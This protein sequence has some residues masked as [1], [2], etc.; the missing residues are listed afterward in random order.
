MMTR[1]LLARVCAPAG[2]GLLPACK[3]VGHRCNVRGPP[4]GR[5]SMVIAWVAIVRGLIWRAASDRRHEGRR[6]VSVSL[7]LRCAALEG[8]VRTVRDTS[9][10]SDLTGRRAVVD[11][12]RQVR[13]RGNPEAYGFRELETSGD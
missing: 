1:H 8:L 10:G 5:C 3:A 6:A 2:T 4:I 11:R 7:V 13:Q 12:W 9:A